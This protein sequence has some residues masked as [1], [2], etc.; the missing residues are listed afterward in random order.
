MAWSVHGG[1]VHG[2]S[3]AQR[4][5]VRFSERRVMGDVSHRVVV[6]V[7]WVVC[8]TLSEEPHRCALHLG[9]L[10]LSSLSPHTRSSESFGLH[11]Q[12]PQSPPGGLSP[13]HVGT[14]SR[15]QARGG[16][17]SLVKRDRAGESM[18]VNLAPGSF[19]RHWKEREGDGG[20]W[21]AL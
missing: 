6:K 15:A 11:P 8:E 10:R 17:Y 20:R 16:A 21:R 9:S 4:A 18:M 3:W 14:A 13:G 12:P 1:T 7:K 19:R 2:P 5:S